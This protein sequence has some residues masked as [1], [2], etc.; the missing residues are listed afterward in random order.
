MVVQ[1]ES[2]PAA[3]DYFILQIIST[4]GLTLES[5]SLSASLPSLPLA[6]QPDSKA[7]R[8]ESEP[9]RVK[10]TVVLRERNLDHHSCGL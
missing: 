6:K 3:K 10:R 8:S 5:D 4:R 9:L 7:F 2:L 1:Q